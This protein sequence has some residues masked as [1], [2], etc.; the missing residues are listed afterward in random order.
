M[1]LISP[2]QDISLQSLQPIREKSILSVSFVWVSFMLCDHTNL[3]I[4]LFGFIGDNFLQHLF[5]IS[6][7]CELISW[8]SSFILVLW[9]L[10]DSKDT[11][12]FSSSRL[13]PCLP[14]SF[15]WGYVVSLIW[16][17]HCVAFP[18]LKVLIDLYS[19]KITAASGETGLG[20]DFGNMAVC[21]WQIVDW[22][23]LWEVLGIY[24]WILIFLAS[25]PFLQQTSCFHCCVSVYTPSPCLTRI[26]V[27]QFLLAH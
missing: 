19:G 2:K 12:I 25:F 7:Q 23:R 4:F 3:L 11:D 24:V 13:P 8:L 15:P 10:T 22:Y 27:T 6:W 18:E 16:V 26:Y 21:S 20:L 1:I 9:S 17:F 14:T 5:P